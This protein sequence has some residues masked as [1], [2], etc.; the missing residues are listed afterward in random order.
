MEQIGNT[1]FSLRDAQ[2]GEV[3]AR[4]SALLVRGGD[5]LEST[6]LEFCLSKDVYQA[7][8]KSLAALRISWSEGGL[9]AGT[10][11]VLGNSCAP[12]FPHCCRVVWNETNVGSLVSRVELFKGL[13]DNFK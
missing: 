1:L 7:F 8:G 5:G 12:D 6:Q 13:L 4:L 3:R 9:A 2:S 10:E 11:T